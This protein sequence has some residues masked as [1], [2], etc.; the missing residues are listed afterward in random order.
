MTPSLSESL[1]FDFVRT[2]Q[3][4]K[5]QLFSCNS[6]VLRTCL[7]LKLSNRM[8]K[9]LHGEQEEDMEPMHHQEETV[10]RGI[11]TITNSHLKVAV[12]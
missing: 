7:S 2:L 11:K 9:Q 10:M 5:R 3:T 6:Y 1:S 4:Q 12:L 8:T